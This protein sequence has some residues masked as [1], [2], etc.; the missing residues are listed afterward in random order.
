MTMTRRS[1]WL[2][3]TVEDEERLEAMMAKDDFL[4]AIGRICKP[5]PEALQRMRELGIESPSF[6]SLDFL[7]RVS[8]PG[9]PGYLV[10]FERATRPVSP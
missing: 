4:D 6:E 8:L 1:L 2:T 10:R 7:N 9:D 3:P 5:T